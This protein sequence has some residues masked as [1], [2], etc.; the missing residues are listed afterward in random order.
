MGFLEARCTKI[1]L[2]GDQDSGSGSGTTRAK[3]DRK[4]TFAKELEEESTLQTN[5]SKHQPAAARKISKVEVNLLHLGVSHDGTAD[6]LAHSGLCL[7]FDANLMQP[8]FWTPL[9]ALPISYFM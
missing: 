8:V 9:C 5:D 2:K 4:L 6:L 1:S 7:N 3:I